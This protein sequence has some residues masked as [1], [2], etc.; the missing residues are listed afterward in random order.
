MTFSE[1]I[2]L[3]MKEQHMQKGTLAALTDVSRRTM[4]SWENGI[5]PRWKKVRAIARV[6]SVSVEYLLDDSITDPFYHIAREDSMDAVEEERG[7]HVT[8]NMYYIATRVADEFFG[9]YN[10]FEDHELCFT[11]VLD[12]LARSYKESKIRIAEKHARIA[13]ER[14][15]NGTGKG[16]IPEHTLAYES[17]ESKN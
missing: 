7:V 5:E 4:T 3:A 9:K 6:L 16:D 11:Y 1:K 17:G 8:R 2:N 12:A 10:G 14:Y 13:E 15:F